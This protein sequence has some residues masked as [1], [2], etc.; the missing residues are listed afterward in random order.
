M[1]QQQQQQQQMQPDTVAAT[2]ATALLAP[3]MGSTCALLSLSV[4]GSNALAG[5][6]F[7]ALQ[8]MAGIT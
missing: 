1:Q 6:L 8:Q 4:S 3:A 2:T 7:E 5:R